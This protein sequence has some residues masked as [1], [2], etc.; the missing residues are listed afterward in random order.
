VHWHV[1]NRETQFKDS[2]IQKRAHD[3]DQSIDRDMACRIVGISRLR[4]GV[5]DECSI[6]DGAGAAASAFVRLARRPR[7]L[8]HI[9]EM[10]LIDF[11][12]DRFVSP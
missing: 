12:V 3:G 8:N 9:R 10:G 6:G 4:S 7:I 11:K 1:F 5:A 2:L